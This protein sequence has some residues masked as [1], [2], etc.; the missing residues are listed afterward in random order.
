[1]LSPV[2][3]Y[4]TL[5][6]K[7]KSQFLLIGIGR[8]RTSLG[9]ADYPLFMIRFWAAMSQRPN[10]RLMATDVAV[11]ISNLA[12][13]ITLTQNELTKSNIYGPI[14]GKTSSC[15]LHSDHFR[16]RWRWEFSCLFDDWPKWPKRDGGSKKAQSI[17]G[18]SMSLLNRRKLEGC[19]HKKS[20]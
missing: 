13:L 15:P 2:I 1:M 16:A 12:E 19:H 9:H 4:G 6:N 11:P 17:Y 10:K 20:S 8:K 14:V 7:R 18:N 5:G 3:S